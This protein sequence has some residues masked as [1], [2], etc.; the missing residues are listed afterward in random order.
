MRIVDRNVPLTR[1]SG[2]MDHGL[3]LSEIKAGF[4][5]GNPIARS[6]L[7][8]TLRDFLNL[9]GISPAD[10]TGSKGVLLEG[11]EI[12]SLILSEAL[13]YFY[14]ALYNFYAQDK[15]VEYG[16]STWSHV[17]NY[18]SSY[19]SIHALLRVQGRSLTRIWRKQTDD[20]RISGQAYYIFPFDF[21]NHQYV[22]C[23]NYQSAGHHYPAWHIFYVIYRNFSF[24]PSEF[25]KIFKRRNVDSEFEELEFRVQQNYEPWQ[26]FSEIWNPQVI[27]DLIANYTRLS[28]CEDDKEIE[29]LS[30]LTTDPDYR[31]YA[32]S[33]LRIL[34]CQSILREICATNQS[35][36][37]CLD[38]RKNDVISFIRNVTPREIANSVI[39]RLPS[40]MNLT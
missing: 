32:R 1:Y 34:F 3:G 37:N 26:G 9:Q 33:V 15:L 8:V 7:W 10:I 19:F 27:P 30:R 31:F 11:S 14:R 28:Q 13:D 17:T 24:S 38:Q 21:I 4:G 12:T 36:L 40:L 35:L 16:Y 2:P 20:G 22:I 25:E 18:Y 5:S 6:Q 39:N 23:T 29:T